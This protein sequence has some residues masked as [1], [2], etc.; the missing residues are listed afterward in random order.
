ML[1]FARL[2]PDAILPRR[3]T[4]GSAGL[5][6]HAIGRIL[7]PVGERR[8]IQTGWAV[9]I[10]PG[11]YGRIAPRSGLAMRHGL[12][13]LAGVID[14]DYRGEVCVILHNA[15]GEPFQVEKGDR[16][17]QL[18]IEACA[19]LEPAEVIALPDPATLRGANGFGYTGIGA[20][21]G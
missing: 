9:Q 2:H 8:S 14:Q 11:W 1:P 19:L 21:V 13:V 3:G 18:I 10:P 17:A 20:E 4:T 15:G 16:V 7:I 12:D 5:D 6:L